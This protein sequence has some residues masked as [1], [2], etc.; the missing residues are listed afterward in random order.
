[1]DIVLAGAGG[2]MK[3]LLWQFEESGY[4]VLGY[5]APEAE[6]AE[7][8]I[9]RYKYLGND[10]YLLNMKEDVNV[11]L[12]F[13]TSSLRRRVYNSL[14]ENPHIKFPAIVMKGAVVSDTSVIGR[15]SIICRD[16][17]I[18]T[19]CSIG[20]FA[21]VNIGAHLSHDFKLGDFATVS[22]RVAIAGNV[23]VGR[24]ALI[25]INATIIQGLKVGA[26][27]TV[28]AGAVVTKDVPEGVTVVGVPARPVSNK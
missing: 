8:I 26:G 7:G 4:K 19:D 16:V 3:E 21:F 18:T 17:I 20:E 2:C 12:C 9:G 13:G 6:P 24:D 27:A 1:M 28:G 22:P 15:G 14:K 5:C 11:A 25:G 23:T 10:D